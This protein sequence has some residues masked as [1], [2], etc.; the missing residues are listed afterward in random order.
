MSNKRDEIKSRI[1]KAYNDRYVLDMKTRFYLEANSVNAIIPV[2]R[3][4]LHDFPREL[5]I[6]SEPIERLFQCVQHLEHQLYILMDL[7]EEL[8]DG[9]KDRS[10][11]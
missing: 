1:E 10:Q 5:H 9:E 7:Y 8:E 4:Q 6:I 3:S 11:D 2:I